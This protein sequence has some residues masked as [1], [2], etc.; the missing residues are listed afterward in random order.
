[1]NYP[2]WELYSLGGGTLIAIISILHVYISHL[3]V[4]GGIFIWLT[5]R[6]A[7]KTNDSSLLDYIKSHTWLFLLLTMVFGGISGVGIWFII[8]LVHP[9]A[10]S[11]LIHNFVFGWAI[12]W[13]FFLGEVVALLIYHY[14]FKHLETKIRLKIAFLYALFAWLSLA[15]INAILSFM[16]TPGNWLNTGSFWDGIL[17]PTYLPSLVF[18]TFIATMFAGLFGYVTAVLRKDKDFRIKLMRYCSKWLLIS[19]VGVLLSGLWYYFAVPD[20]IRTTTFLLNQ[21]T[22]LFV[23]VF[24]VTSIVIVIFG[25]LLMLKLSNGLQ[26]MLVTLLVIIGL[27]WIGGFE[28]VREIAR[29]PYVIY[30]FMYSNA[31]LKADSDRLN[32]EGVLANARWSSV[33]KV[34]D[35]NMLEAGRELFNLQCLGCHTLGGVRNN[36]DQ[37]TADYPYLG[38]RSLLEGIGK[39]HS[40]MPQTF[41]TEPERQ[42]LA[43]FLADRGGQPLM[44]DRA[45]CEIRERDVEILSFDAQKS[46]YILLAWNDLGMHCT[47]DCDKWFVIL[48]PANTLEA[49][50]IGRGDNLGVIGNGV[51]LTYAVESGHENPAAHVDFWKYAKSNFG[52]DLQ[53]NIGL[54]GKGLSGTMEYDADAQAYVAHLIPVVPYRDDGEFNPFPMFTIEA[55]DEATGELLAATK[56]IAPVSTEMG[57]KNCHGGEWRVQDRTG[58]SDETAIAI[59]KA[60]DRN[61]GTNLYSEALAGNPKLCQSCHADPALSAEGKPEVLSFSAAMHG[62]HANYMP[63]KDENACVACH[64]ASLMGATRCQRGVHSA[65][66]QNCTSCHGS[67]TDHA[68][69]LL[70]REKDKPAAQ[71]LMHNL[72]PILVSSVEEIN[73]RMPWVNEPKCLT[74]HVDFQQPDSNTSGYN[75][76]SPEFSELYRRRTGDAGIRCE[77]CHNSPHAIYPSVNIYGRDLSNMQPLQYMGTRYAIGEN[78]K[79]Q[80]CHMQSMEDPIHHKNMGHKARIRMDD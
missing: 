41:G 71:G 80:T 39:V 5:D 8:G 75:E 6:R 55:H 59:L 23:S 67:L 53:P 54:S 57:C 38:V 79:C 42:A 56:V 72:H 32:N 35:D 22:G 77:A 24:F 48:P 52:V 66:N 14:Y 2:I 44:K 1:M 34:T 37:W 25:A 21:D 50:L 73:P 30:D 31:I 17:N 18:R 62:W 28:Y 33:G 69:S 76:W 29:K 68:L 49:Q 15:V 26:R 51:K 74:C 64:P 16:L 9:A 13:V 63:L 58:V 4:G 12:E 61:S 47:S 27:G 78:Q 7:V 3:A 36:I 11:T 46:G 45:V 70:V 19:A 43:M 60:H 40:Y 20:Q 65:A 10:T